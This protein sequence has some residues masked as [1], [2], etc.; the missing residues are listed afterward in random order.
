MSNTDLELLKAALNLG[1]ATI[2]IALGWAVGQR[3]TVYWNLRQKQREHDMTTAQEFHKLYGEFFAI[4][5]LW[6]YHLKASGSATSMR[7]ELLSRACMAEGSVESLF[8]RL[9]ASRS[10]TVDQARVLGRFRQGYQSL[11]QAIR[12]GRRLDWRSSKHAEY[13][14]F[15]SLATEVAVL[16]VSEVPPSA[17]LIEARAESLLQITSNEWEERWW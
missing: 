12:D 16:I 6:N 7:N 10:L 3:L 14:A 5:K 9:A 13:V 2:T 8:V 4:W 17:G 11:R 1:T 15:K